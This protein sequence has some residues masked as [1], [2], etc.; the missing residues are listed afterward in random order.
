MA[1]DIHSDTVVNGVEH[2]VSFVETLIVSPLQAVRCMSFYF[3]FLSQ[4][5][6]ILLFL[7]THGVCET[8]HANMAKSLSPLQKLVAILPKAACSVPFGQVLHVVSNVLI[9]SE[10]VEGDS[11]FERGI[12][13]IFLVAALDHVSVIRQSLAYRAIKT[14]TGRVTIA[15]SAISFIV[16]VSSIVAVSAISAV[17]AVSAIS[18]VGSVIVIGI[19][20]AVGSIGAVIAVGSIGAVIAVGSIG[21]IGVVSAVIRVSTR[22]FL[23]PK[24]DIALRVCFKYVYCVL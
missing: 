2:I 23:L 5:L 18:A 9:A 19:I 8:I 7:L 14:T 11:V 1:S 15:I 3:P 12:I 21:S 22:V 16:T 24:V 20:G 13:N 4:I 17:R 10:V 6:F